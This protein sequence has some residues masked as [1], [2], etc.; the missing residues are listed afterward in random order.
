MGNVGILGN[1][2]TFGLMYRVGAAPHPTVAPH[3][4]FSCYFV[5]Q[6]MFA[7]ITPAIIIGSVADRINFHALCIFVPLWHMVVYCP[8]GE[9][10][11][12]FCTHA[13][14]LC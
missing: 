4:P 11:L 10:C 8:V 9:P 14:L 1:P 2:A 5:F 13:F 6:L 12:L 3:I 7:I